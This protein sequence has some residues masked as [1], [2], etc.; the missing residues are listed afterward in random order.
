MSW[1]YGLVLVGKWYLLELKLLNYEVEIKNV[2]RYNWFLCGVYSTL[3]IIKFG[4]VR[5]PF[6]RRGR[7]ISEGGVVADVV[8]NFPGYSRVVIEN[9]GIKFRA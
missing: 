9:S 3:A 5:F 7:L 6:I 8:V 1:Y 4:T 2:G